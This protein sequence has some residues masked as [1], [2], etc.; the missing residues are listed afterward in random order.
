[1]STMLSQIVISLT[2]CLS[3][4]QATPRFYLAALEKNGCET[5]SGLGPGDEATVYP[6]LA[7][8]GV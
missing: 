2:R 3:R 8:F 5:K 6:V 4:P 7:A 1:M